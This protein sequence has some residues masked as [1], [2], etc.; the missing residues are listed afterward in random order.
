[1]P[2]PAPEPKGDEPVTAAV[3]SCSVDDVDAYAA[4]AVE[5]GG[6]MAVEK[7]E[8]PGAGWVA[9]IKDTEGNIIGV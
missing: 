5:H 3:L 2:R 9:Y 7:M 1:M 4:R 8:I 6:Q